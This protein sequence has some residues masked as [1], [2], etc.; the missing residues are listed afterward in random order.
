MFMSLKRAMDI[1]LGSADLKSGLSAS[2]ELRG[3]GVA[4]GPCG[5]ETEPGP[6]LV[7]Q[8]A[9]PGGSHHRK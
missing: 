6:L 3:P 2:Q 9:S 8:R 5:E 7:S 1:F 4:F